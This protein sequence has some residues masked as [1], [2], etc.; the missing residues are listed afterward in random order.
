MNTILRPLL[1]LCLLSTLNLELSTSAN[2]Q[3]SLTPPAGP[4][5]ASMKTL[6]QVEA[7][8]PLVAGAPGVAIDGAGTITIS[9]PGS[10]YLTRNV[11]ITTNVNGIE[12]NA[13]ATVDLNGFGIIGTAA[14]ITT[15]DAITI[16]TG[17][18]ATV[19]NGFIKGGT[20]LAGTTYTRAGFEFGVFAD[21]PAAGV[22]SSVNVSDLQVSAVRGN[23]IFLR[24]VSRVDRCTVQVVGGSG[25]N[26]AYWG[27]VDSPTADP[28]IMCVVTGCH[29]SNCGGQFGIGATNVSA[30]FGH[31]NSAAGDSYSAAC[32]IL[33]YQVDHSTGWATGPGGS[34]AI[35]TFKYGIHGFII[36]YSSGK[37]GTDTDNAIKAYT[38]AVACG[39]QGGTIFSPQKHLGTP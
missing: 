34:I 31:T 14:A 19:R 37:S 32:G 39:S 27:R 21:A 15:G 9:Q 35:G 22:I 38:T 6:D 8:T 16:A 11:T 7:R 4:P 1:A 13:D 23:G 25:I 33:A 10:Y 26:G 18:N 29:A 28:G 36:S 5:V 30:S 12:I 24:R 20:T 17:A 2:A 3:G